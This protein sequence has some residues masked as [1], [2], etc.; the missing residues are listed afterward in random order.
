MAANPLSSA[1]VKRDYP[2]HGNLNEACHAASSPSPQL[3]PRPYT[4]IFAA[5]DGPP[6]QIWQTMTTTDGLALPQVVPFVFF[7]ATCNK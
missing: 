3:V 5:I 4:A 6:D 7:N 1:H 2:M